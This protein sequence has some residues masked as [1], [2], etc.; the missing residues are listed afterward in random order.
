MGQSVC[1]LH[2]FAR[3]QCT[4]DKLD[5]LRLQHGAVLSALPTRPPQTHRL[6]RWLWLSRHR[7][8]HSG[9]RPGIVVGTA[10][11]P[12]RMGHGKAPHSSSTTTAGSCAFALTVGRNGPHRNAQSTYKNKGMR[13]R[14]TGGPSMARV[15]PARLHGRSG[16]RCR[17]MPPPVFGL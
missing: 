16:S 1:K 12:E 6:R 5:A 10:R 2:R 11:W 9:K 4:A 14:K 17:D 13:S 3:L 15:A 8:A 7:T